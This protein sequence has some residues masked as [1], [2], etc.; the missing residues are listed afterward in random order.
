M[1][2]VLCVFAASAAAQYPSRLI[3]IVVPSAPGDGSDL[4]ARLI[5]D[6]LS[7]VL[8][9]PVIIDNK[10]GAGGVVGTEFAARQPADIA[11]WKKVVAESGAKID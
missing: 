4:A 2:A 5:S 11:K 3:H 7:A 9:Q 8:G 6:K 10:L 1:G